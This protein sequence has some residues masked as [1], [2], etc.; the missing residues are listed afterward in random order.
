MKRLS[1][2]P[3]SFWRCSCLLPSPRPRTR[4]APA[5]WSCARPSRACS[6]R[7]GRC[8]RSGTYPPRHRAHLSC[9]LPP[10]R[11]AARPRRSD[12]S[13]HRAR[14]ASLRAEPSRAPAFVSAGW[15]QP[16]PTFSLRVEAAD[17]AVL[18]GRLTPS[19]PDFI[20]P[21][22][23]SRLACLFDLSSARRR[24]YP[25]RRRSPSLRALPHPAGPRAFA[26]S[27][28]PSPPSPS[29]IPSRWRRPPLAWSTFR[30]AP[31]EAMIALS[32]VFLASELLR[33]PARR[34][35][36]TRSYPWLVA[37]SFG[38]LHGLGFAG[39]LAEIGL[40]QGEIPLALFSFNVGV[41]LRPARLHRRRAVP[42]PIW[43]RRLVRSTPSWAPR[44]TAYAIGCTA[45]Y[46]VFERLA[47]AT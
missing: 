22:R 2:L 5:I 26:S 7:S 20:V 40:P 38:L 11:R 21:A 35:G 36:I 33:D 47:A 1:A 29:P 13:V 34:S 23:P 4:S 27:S 39:A 32:I 25:D 42:G 12:S 31:V 8:R 15:R 16:R 44:A 41:E 45:A 10:D 9:L 19:H 3:A 28:P 24:A 17:G 43:R 30:A 6:R 14:P 46:W 37:F 18:T